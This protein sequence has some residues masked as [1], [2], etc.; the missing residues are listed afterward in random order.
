[1]VS[2][3]TS[4]QSVKG[5]LDHLDNVG[6]VRYIHRPADTV[7][8]ALD[9]LT[10]WPQAQYREYSL[11]YLGLH[12]GAG[13]LHIGRRKLALEELGEA[14]DGRCKGKTIYFGSCS[15][16]GVPKHRIE[17]FR[18]QVQARCVA[19]YEKDVDWFESSAFDLLLF[20]ALTR[21]RRIDAVDRWLRNEYLG[22]VRRLGFKMYYG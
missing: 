20:E 14:L 16:L 19:G 11:G 3:L 18:R 1:M 5:L 13:Q 7:D 12:G 4:R 21:Y 10:R 8:T 6:Q 9:Y 17:R 2:R 22:F 15:V